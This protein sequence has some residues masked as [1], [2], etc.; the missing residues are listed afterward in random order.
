[1][2]WHDRFAPGKKD[3]VNHDHEWAEGDPYTLEA[4]PSAK[5]PSECGVIFPPR[6]PDRFTPR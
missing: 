2:A 5:V 4:G 6:E 3:S 1:M